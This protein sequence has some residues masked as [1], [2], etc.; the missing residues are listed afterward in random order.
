MINQA[1]RDDAGGGRRAQILDAAMHVMSE[2][3]FRGA[4]IKR[5]AARAGLK[6]P[7]LIYWYFK[8]KHALFE[9]MLDYM[10][11]VLAVTADPEPLLDLPPDQVLPRIVDG[12]LHF[13]RSP[14]VGR[15]VRLMLSEAARDQTAA[16]F[17]AERGP[18]VVVRFLERYLARQVA[19]GRLRPHDPRA[20]A[21]AFMGMLVVYILG[22]EVVVVVGEGFPP[23]DAYG[24][25]V[26]SIFLEG[27]I[28]RG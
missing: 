2:H 16:T 19:L 21:R 14:V 17:F 24:A 8:D 25:L 22:R 18:L 15:F 20:A 3:G 5:I 13:A 4:S 26:T 10:A 1:A 9:A 27:L 23:A 11:P 12:F 7:A 6:S 28:S